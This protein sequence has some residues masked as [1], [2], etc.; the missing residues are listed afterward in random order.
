[1]DGTGFAV[2]FGFSYNGIPLGSLVV[3]SNKIY[4]TTSQGGSYN[5]GSIFSI[6]IGGGAL[7]N[8]YSFAYGQPPLTD[9]IGATPVGGLVLSGNVLYGTTTTSA[10]PNIHDQSNGD[11]TVFR[12][13]T[14]GTGFTVL[15][16]FNGFDG[17]AP[18][19][20][21]TL[22][23][24][25]L[26]GTAHG[27]AGYSGWGGTYWRLST[28]GTGFVFLFGGG[29]NFSPSSY[30]GVVLSSDSIYGTLSPGYNGPNYGDAFQITTNG[31]RFRGLCEF[32]GGEL[33]N[34][35]SVYGEQPSLVLQGRTLYGTT[36]SGGSSGK[37]LLFRLDL[38]ISPT[39]LGIQ[40]SANTVSLIWT[41]PI[42]T[43]QAA[44]VITG[45]YTNIPGA[46]SPF[47]ESS[48]ASKRYFRLKAN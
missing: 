12:I 29:N 23:G 30:G 19:A 1:M 39:P 36:P 42:F 18:L 43:L 14:D 44:P 24:N 4:G 35:Q 31:T 5:Q 38:P 26:Y 11:G 33:A 27:Y 37:G 8:L 15:H 40:R 25:T 13:N 41:N 45:T 20:A 16:R 6:G 47:T 32:T 28:D 46:T 3:S 7:H 9:N 10:T 34:V 22:S 48:G 21:L 2:I 17:V